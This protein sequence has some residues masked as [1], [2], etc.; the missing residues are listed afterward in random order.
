MIVVL[1]GLLALVIGFGIGC[2]VE[3]QKELKNRKY[4]GT[5]VI[6]T[7]SVKDEILALKLD[8]DLDTLK[9]K[10]WMSVKVEVQ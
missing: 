3:D 5:F 10:G 8:T 6:N 2:Y 9:D 1:Y 7:S 4:D